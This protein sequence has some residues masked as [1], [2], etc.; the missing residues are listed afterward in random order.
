M[1]YLKI[2]GIDSQ[3]RRMGLIVLTKNFREQIPITKGRSYNL[4]FVMGKRKF[5]EFS[6]QFIVD[7]FEKSVK[8][9]SN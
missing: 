1:L 7:K 6:L 2:M 8:L 9:E 3:P 4:L 5:K